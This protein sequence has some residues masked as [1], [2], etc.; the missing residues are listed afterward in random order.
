[1]TKKTML[2]VLP[3][4][5]ALTAC[6]GGGNSSAPSSEPAT[7]KVVV[8][9][10]TTF[11]QKNGEA[12]AK[13][14]EDFSK[15]I[16]EKTGVEVVI[17]T[18]YQGAY[19]DIK[20]KITQGFSAG[21][22]PTMAIAYPDHVANYLANEP[23]PGDYVYNIADYLNDAEIGLGKQAYLDDEGGIEDFVEAFID[24]GR[25]YAR[26]G[27]FSM[28]FMKSSEVMF[29]NF[30]AVKAL[31]KIAH[32]EITSNDQIK[33]FVATMD[34]D[35][36]LDLSK[37]A[38]ENKGSVLSTLDYPIWY[39]SDSNLFI[40]KLYQQEIGYCSIDSNLKGKIDFESGENRTRAEAFVNSLV[41]AKDDHL[42]T[43]KGVWNKYGSD[44][45][46]LGQC[47]F[48]IGSS[49]GTGYNDPEGGAFEVGVAR[50]PASNNNPL[51]VS[52][53]P[54]L[55]FLK[56]PSISKA[57]NDLRMKYA[58]QFAKYI[59]NAPTNVYLSIY[60]SEGYLPVKYSA[61][62]TAEFADFMDNGEVYAESYK[63]LINDIKGRYF[64]APVFKG[65][66][67]LR[68]QCGGIVTSALLGNKGTV[69]ELFDAAIAN[70]KK[71]F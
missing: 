17:E 15:I 30:D 6:G 27:M 9:F 1:M 66:A 24:E 54:T 19:D 60:G 71:G 48:E 31:M 32:P 41:K 40:S 23:N 38:L 44:A 65:S 4:L 67:E 69:T 63:V 8:P 14:A 43:T 52:Q 57:Q 56:N 21:N 16:K 7:D 53:G 18:T 42:L 5:F 49:G 2:S 64:N 62:D 22:V 50:V 12:L 68:D 29:Y 46:K 70:A 47:I 37:I 25:H 59:T 39:D 28:P 34:W 26:E 10:W 11:G 61:Y 55:T 33:E 36:L 13:K 58:W 35:T 51:Y 3:L 45:F 20:N